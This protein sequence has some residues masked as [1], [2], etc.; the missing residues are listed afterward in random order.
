MQ[1][2]RWQEINRIFH[3]ALDVPPEGRPR[4]VATESK[5]DPDLQSHV[6]RLLEAD[7]KDEDYLESPLIPPGIFSSAFSDTPQL[8]PGQILCERFHILRT[9]GSGGMG[10]VFEAYDSELAV[11]VALK[12]IRPEIAANPQALARFRQEVRLARRITH[13]NVCRTYD[14][15]RD[16]RPNPSGPPTNLVFLTMEFLPGET[17]AE[18]LKRTPR[19]THEEIL[20]IASQ[21]AAALGAAHALGIVHRD[22]K[23]GNIMLV[24]PG[25]NSRQPARVVITDFGLAR[26][27]PVFSAGEHSITHHSSHSNQPIGTLAYMA[28]EQMDGRPISAATDIYAFGLILFEMATGQRAF[29]S[30]NLLSG[31]AQRLTGPAPS[32]TT[33]QPSL[34]ESVEQ[35]IHGCLRLNPEDRFQTAEAV[36][37]CLIGQAKPPAVAAIPSVKPQPESRSAH[38]PKPFVPRKSLLSY[39]SIALLVAVSLFLL[40]E[41]YSWWKGNPAVTPGALV[42]LAPVTNQ[43]GEKSLDNIAELLQASLEQSAHINLLDQ[44]RVGDIMQNMT[45]PADT[46]I[47]EPIG[48]EIALRANAARVVFA[49]VTG[50]S[51]SYS[52]NID[53]QRLDNTPQRY[54]DHWTRSFGWHTSGQTRSSGT[55]SSELLTVVRTSSDWIRIEVGESSSDIARQDAAPEDVTTSNWQA[56]EEYVAAEKMQSRQ[57]T[58]QAVIA[59]KNA[60]ALDNHFSLAYGRLGDLL[61]STGQ[62]QEGFRAYSHALEPDQNGRLARRER[63]R[64]LGEFAIDSEDFPVAERAYRDITL[65]YNKDYSGWSYRGYPLLMMGRTD[66]AIASLKNAYSID[67]TKANAPYELARANISIGSFTEASQWASVL[68]RQGATGLSNYIRGATKF[69]QRDYRGAA[70]AFQE[71]QQSQMLS[72]HSWSFLLLARLAA[73]Q[74]D[75]PRASKELQDGIAFDSRT[76]LMAMEADKLIARA[77]VECHSGDFGSCL[78]DTRSGIEMEGSPQRFMVASAVLGYAHLHSREPYASRFRKEILN[79]ERR[80][81]Q[82]SFGLISD[83]ARFRVRGEALLAMGHTNG[84]LAE[85][86]RASE[87]DAQ[88]NGREYLARTLEVAARQESNKAVAQKSIRSALDAYAAIALHPNLIWFDSVDLLPGSYADQLSAYLKLAETAGESGGQVA[89]ARQALRALR[90]LANGTR[91][92]SDFQ[93]P[94]RR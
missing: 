13:P 15:D 42:Y 63:D 67:Q 33:L 58:A 83:L 69:L 39:A 35:A 22:I 25:E 90:G 30:S 64:I 21:I 43:T 2:D 51:G 61:F 4:F 78:T 20:A 18:R 44:G 62:Y 5:D 40:G 8:Q 91:E 1:K 38:Q 73:E 70:L 59:L 37:E 7:A 60:V 75:Y 87:L 54:R 55:F 24:P 46:P 34:P 31:I 53:I 12:L 36:L 76:G 68:D 66:E 93:Q 50:A 71:M 89:T 79:V 3:A 56:L 9:V 19:L 16:T 82:E 41:R 27:D 52:L 10:Q 81:P 74:G 85:F 84:A 14:L 23:P 48:R 26:L 72:L 65:Y 92:S 29:P 49:A 80:F 77:Y 86:R 11:N 45:K 32:P 6:E 57:E 47:T 94:N 88:A 28:P 17:L